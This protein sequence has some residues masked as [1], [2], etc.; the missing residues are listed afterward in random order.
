MQ[1][2]TFCIALFNGTSSVFVW[3]LWHQTGAQYSVGA[4]T[5]A[6][7]EVRKVLNE[8][9]QLVPDSF[10]PAPLGK[11]LFVLVCANGFCMLGSDPG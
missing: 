5:S 10:S 1:P 4:N 3:V 6:V 11:T 2:E 8:V 9:P 7:V